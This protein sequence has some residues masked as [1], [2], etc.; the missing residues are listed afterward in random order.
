MTPPQPSSFPERGAGGVGV[1]APPPRDDPFYR[2]DGSTPLADITPGTVLKTRSFRYHIFGFPTLLK[3]TQL[4]YRSTTQ[5]SRPAVNVTSIIEPP[6][7]FDK[8]RVVSYQSAYDS[9]NPNDEPSYAISGGLRLGGLIPNVEV[10]VFGAF[11]AAGATIVVPDTEGQ[12]AAFAAGPEYGMYTLD[13]LRAA[14]NSSAIPA[15]AKIALL[16]YSG[17]ALAT[18]WAAELAPTYAPEVDERLLC[19]AMGGVLVDPAH[20]LHYIEGTPFWSGVLP[21]ALVGIARAFEIDLSPY[22]T[23]SGKKIFGEMQTASIINVLGQYPGLKWSDLVSPDYPTPESLPVYVRSANQLIMGTGGTPTIPLFI[24]QGANGDLELTPGNKPGIGPGDG[25]MIAGDVR[26]LAREYCSRGVSVH[27]EQ[28]DALSHIWSVPVWLPEAI[29]W[30]H[31]RYAGLPAT[32]N[33]A[34][35][36]PGNPLDPIPQP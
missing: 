7:R 31:R 24:G 6:I 5:L 23:P 36:K 26:T 12:Q 15:D 16:G 13:S 35:I 9:L 4:L 22:L 27:Y 1:A 34:S 21:M 2:Y 32:G 3:T 33:C 18:E 28:Y 25:V 14:L 10:A 20:N 30:I 8:R 11:L 19:A 17:G 29:G